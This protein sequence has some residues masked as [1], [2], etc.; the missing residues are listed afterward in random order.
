MIYPK[1]LKDNGTIGVPAPSKGAADE[2]KKA[3]TENA[4]K[5]L[6]ELGY[7][8]KLSKNLYNDEM[9]R[10]ASPKVR[11]EEV[12]QMFKDKDIDLILCLSG[13]EFLVEM[14]PYVNFD[15]IKDNPRYVCGFSDPTGLL[16]PITTKYDIATIY[17]KNF[18]NFGTQ[19]LF[20]N[21]KDFL[22][23]IKGN[24][25]TQNN[26]DYYEAERIEHITG[27]ENDNLTEKVYWN[28]LGSKEVNVK[29]RIIGGCIDLIDA[30]S[31]TKYDGTLE[32][33]E[34]YKEDGIIWY[35][36]N[37]DLSTEDIIRTLWK[38]NELGYFKYT[39]LVIFGRFGND[40][41]FVGYD[42][43]GCLEDSI[44]TS[45][46]IPIVYDADF[47]HKAPCLTVINGSIATVKV[48]NGKG[49]ISYELK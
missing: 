27:L 3:K 47:S 12:N 42:T 9:A 25:V 28:I 8:L 16:F 14:L 21:Q 48:K 1:F 40:V 15:L 2:L 13:G 11:G 43:K 19:D 45:L 23:I 6:K 5:R 41:S 38:F 34:R 32:F 17:G 35:F 20:Q 49:S 46:N 22:E 44:L 7:E 18:S 4:I 26:S 36:D 30:L 37:C 24:L 39:K 10:S 31:G 33:I 29:G